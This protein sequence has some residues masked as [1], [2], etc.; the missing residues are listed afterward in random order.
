M[1]SKNEMHDLCDQHDIILVQET[2]LAND[3][4][5]VLS[6]IHNDFIGNGVSSINDELRINVGRPFGGTGIIW[7]KNINK[8]C[9]FRKY[10][11]DRIVGLEFNCDSFCA[12]F[13][14]VYMPYDCSDNYDDYMF[15]LNKL[16]TI[17]DNFTSPYIFVCGDFN[18]NM[19]VQSRFGRELQTAC[20]ENSL[21]ISD[22][23]LLPA[24]TFTFVS[25]S[26]G[27]TSW[28]D[29]IITTNS[30]HALLRNVHIMDA[31]ISSDH[32]PVC[33]EVFI[34]DLNI[35]THVFSSNSTDQIS[36]NWSNATDIDLHNYS[37]CT[38]IELSK[39]RVPIEA[40]SCTDV[41]CTAHQKDIDLFYNSICNTLHGCIKRCIQPHKQNSAHNVTGWNEHVKHFYDKARG[42]FVWW[43][44]HNKPRN[45]PLYRAM[46]VARAQ[47]KYALRQCRLD[48]LTHANTK[49]AN[50]MECHDVN[51]FWKEVRRHGKSKSALSTCVD[52]VTG[53]S[54]I[55]DMWRSHFSNLLN[56]SANTICKDYVCDSFKNL[57]FNQGMCVSVDEVIGLVKDLPPGKSCGKDGLNG[58]CLRY[59]NSLLSVLLSFCFT[60]MFKHSY[61]PPA[62]L[63][64]VIVPLVKNKCGDLSDKNNYRPIALSSII[65][66]VFEKIILLRLEE[67][68]WTADNQ[69][70]FKSSHSTDLCVYALT[71]FIEYFKSRSSSVFVAFLDASK[72]F[73]KLNHWILFKKLID[74]HVPLYLVK[75]LCY[76]YQQQTMCVRWGST[77]STMF[78]VSNGVRQGGV[79]S[80]R[81]FNIYMDGLS[82]ALNRSGTGGSFGGRTLNHMMYADDI[83]IISLSSAGLQLLLNM[84]NDY[85]IEHDLVFNV[86]KSQCMF[87]R[88]SVNK[89][90][91][92][93]SIYLNGNLIEFTNEAKYLGV[94]LHS[95]LK[96]TIDVARQMRK[97]YMQA[98][99]LLRNFRYCTEQVKCRLFQ[100][101]CTNMYCCQLW[102]NST[103][104][105]INKLRTSYNSVLR[106][107]LVISKPYSA[108][109]MFVC[110]GI[111]TFD[112]ILRKTVYRFKERIQIS[113]NSIIAGCLSPTVF[114]SSPIRKWWT[115]LLYII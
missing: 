54:D 17:I 58:E 39:I 27:S 100:S 44:A 5:T 52:G 9:T 95:K 26:H 38:K 4:L 106:R 28:L 47:F 91:A 83:C 102:F 93:P 110:R 101:Y 16:L 49:L 55:A 19:S 64:S 14:C 77:T 32:L 48:E 8:Y 10:D 84:C 103:K 18:A 82:S 68:L 92:L 86:K 30:S 104:T 57:C 59:A 108:S 88:C 37:E 24:D 42:E 53:E 90:S 35:C 73:D 43:R 107:L 80:P 7:N 50:H 62:I 105:S 71:E 3:Q 79:L 85:C 40:I 20:S 41:F 109:A 45:G 67:Y 97:F 23:L 66:K 65:S 111:P 60:C 94:L 6:N 29:H 36:Y 33:F 11:S 46:S 34:D 99:L 76:W 63:D 22:K 2:W 96:T 115:S 98:N 1:T 89:K 81:L 25:S 69:F 75:I 112:E 114:L 56:S 87:F 12:L 70:G 13:L 61:L 21:C 78:H 72:A 74:R 15:H 51:N 31:F 113:N